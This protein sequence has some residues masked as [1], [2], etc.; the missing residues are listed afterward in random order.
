MQTIVQEPCSTMSNITTLIICAGTKSECITSPPLKHASYLI[1]THKFH[2]ISKQMRIW[3]RYHIFQFW[4]R[5]LKGIVAPL[6]LYPIDLFVHENL[7]VISCNC[8]ILYR[9]VSFW[10]HLVI[11]NIYTKGNHHHVYLSTWIIYMP[12]S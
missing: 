5:I 7:G 6:N 9:K 8:N 12:T 10:F 1:H 4:S 2:K 3:L 11:S